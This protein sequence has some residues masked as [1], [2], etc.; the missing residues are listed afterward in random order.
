[1]QCI[2]LDT[3]F[4]P[5]PLRSDAVGFLATEHCMPINKKQFLRMADAF[6]ADHI[7][8]GSDSPWTDIVKSL[9]PV[10]ESGLSKP[11]LDA[12]LGGNAARLLELS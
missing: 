8:F 4:T 10:K 6:G 2:K 1:M 7:L 9:Q 3:A 11:T 12:V 5:S